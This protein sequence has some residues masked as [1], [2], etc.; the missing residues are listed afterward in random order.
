VFVFPKAMKDRPGVLYYISGCFANNKVN[1]TQIAL[2][3][4]RKKLGTYYFYFEFA[5]HIS[6][7]NIQKALKDLEPHA[8]FRVL[9]SFPKS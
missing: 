5:G 3:P 6:D 4:S 1:L 8:D 7:K 2:R 9:G